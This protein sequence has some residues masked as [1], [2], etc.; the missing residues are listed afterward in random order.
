MF[1]ENTKSVHQSHVLEELNIRVEA[2]SEKYLGLPV[3][4]GRSKKEVFV[5]LKERI[6]KKD[7]RLEGEDVVEG[8]ERH[9]H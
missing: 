7:P 4:V 9:I 1:S 5:Y 8:R 2:R 3:Y 6:W